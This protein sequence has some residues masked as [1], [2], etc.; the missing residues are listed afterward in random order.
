MGI[1]DSLFAKKG[2]AVP[3]ALIALNQ[4]NQLA[5]YVGRNP[6]GRQF[7]L[8]TPSVMTDG[9]AGR[10]FIALYLFDPT[11]HFVEARIDYLGQHGVALSP[12]E[13]RQMH[14]EWIATLG[15]I[16][17]CRIEIRP[18]KVERFGV[19]FGLIAHPPPSDKGEWSATVEPG[20][21][22]TFYAPW[23]SGNYET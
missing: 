21:A 13:S 4:D 23:D 22:M 5:R 3:P 12:A 15:P 1:L 8:T 7:F 17:F 20:P 18:F 6:D 11:G 14:Q 10:D 19:T 2:P 16:S 9:G